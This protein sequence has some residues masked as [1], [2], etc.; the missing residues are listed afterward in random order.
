MDL[1]K[2]K[3]P[4]CHQNLEA[5]AEMFGKMNKCPVCNGELLVPDSRLAPNIQLGEFTLLKPIGIG[6][7]GEVWLAEQQSVERKVALKIMREELADDPYFKQRFT[8]ELKSSGRLHHANIATIYFAGAENNIQYMAM[9]YIDGY[10]LEQKIAKD[11]ALP[12][13][14]AIQIVLGVAEALDYAWRNFKTI[15]RDIKPSNIMIN[16]E[17]TVKLL[18]LGIARNL[19]DNQQTLLISGQIIGTPQYMSPE[20]AENAAYIDCRSDI[21]SLGIVLCEMLTGTLPF[22]AEATIEML[23]QH[24]FAPRPDLH[25]SANISKKNSEL[26]KRMIAQSPEERFKDWQEVIDEISNPADFPRLKS[27]FI[28]KKIIGIAAVCSVVILILLLYWPDTQ[29]STSSEQNEEQFQVTSLPLSTEIIDEPEAVQ[30]QI[31]E[32]KITKNKDV[33]IVTPEKITKKAPTKNYKTPENIP[34]DPD[35]LAQAPTPPPMESTETESDKPK[36]KDL[37]SVANRKIQKL[38]KILGLTDKQTKKVVKILTRMK[39]KINKERQKAGRGKGERFS[40]FRRRSEN[41]HENTIQKINKIRW[42]AHE[43]LRQE[44]TP[45]QYKKFIKLT[46]QLMRN[47]RPEN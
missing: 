23:A 29:E 8:R 30:E 45:E 40:S 47:H 36:K 11:G 21:Y 2:F 17:G 13:E 38:Q 6:G 41:R 26:V 19:V 42:E 5:E 32:A 37:P 24:I 46:L 43:E 25:M 12:E 35:E 4:H 39:E 15:H 44:M 22:T 7:M 33:V 14:E 16:S 3:C 9:E 10:T 20:Q 27:S 1:L 28:R 31:P 34:A 18:D